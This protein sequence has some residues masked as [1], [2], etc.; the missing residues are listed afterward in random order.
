VTALLSLVLEFDEAYAAE[1][2]KR[3]L[4]DFSDLEHLAARILTDT[5]SGAPTETALAVSRRYREIMVDEYQDVSRVQERIFNAVSRD[6][7][8]IFMVGDVKQ[9][10]YRF[11]LA[12]PAI[13]LEKYKAYRDAAEAGPDEPRRVLLSTNFR[14]KAGILSAVNFVFKNVMSEDFGEMAYTEREFLYPGRTDEEPPGPAVELD[15]LDMS[16]AD[17]EKDGEEDGEEPEKTEVEAAFV[18]ARIEELLRSGMAVPDGQGGTRTIGCGDFAILLRSV[19]DKAPVYERALAERNIPASLPGG[20]GFFT[21]LEVSVALSLLGVIDNPR[22]DIPLIAVL[23]SPIY[24]FTPDELAVIRASDRNA[25][26]YGALVRAAETDAKCRSFLYELSSF[27][28]V[29][30]DMPADRFLWHVYNRTD[31][32]AVMGALKGGRER[33][34]NLMALVGLA[35][36]YEAGGYRGLFGFMTLV[37]KLIENGEEPFGAA[38]TAGSETAAAGAVRIMSIHKS[39][40]LEFPIVIIADTAKRFNK[41]DASAPLLI[42]AGLGVGAKRTDLERRI[43]YPTLARLAVARR[44][45]QE[46]MSEELRVLYVAMTRAKERLVV[47]STFADAGKELSKLEKEAAARSEAELRFA[48]Q[49]LENARSMAELILLPA[50]TRPEAGCLRQ[51]PV[52]LSPDDGYPW[53]IRRAAIT[54]TPA[55]SRKKVQ[56]EPP[57]VRAREEDIMALRENLGYSYPYL[58][59]AS[60]PS[61]LTATGLKGRFADYEAAEEAA[62][63]EYAMAGASTPGAN[64]ENTRSRYAPANRPAFITQRTSL[65]AAER[66]TALHLTMQY[67]DY[68]RCLTPDGV[69][70]EVAR[71]KA[72]NFLSEKQAD[73]VDAEKIT[74]FFKGPL[75]RRVMEAEKLYREFKFSLLVPAEDYS[76]GSA[77]GDEI[78]L[79]GVVDCCFEE[80][81]ALHVIDFKTDNVTEETLEEK[82]RLYAPQLNA[83]GHAM[84]RITGLPAASRIIWFF[85][86]DKAVQ[87]E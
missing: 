19:K 2:R 42:H 63:P 70:S 37:R 74:A 40:G 75:G 41:R 43:E 59:A 28:L 3:S 68:G 9:S 66:G 80:G 56:P 51:G 1:K 60:I 10:I 67:I 64:M 23:R 36:R 86:L 21:A 35:A 76:Y 48:P 8:N 24:N 39:K 46:T 79:Q 47:V 32:L 82:K 14:S 30:P 53:D 5:E 65:T 4:A 26:F 44:L 73:A 17:G 77:P 33:R 69:R 84:E 85:A 27:R 81:G 18:A 6:G 55:L 57:R 16:G 78:L 31:M 34:S 11:R 7:Q 71:L 13:F 50:L 83:Y 54:G 61:K 58:D 45:N 49:V 12:D 38:A 87:I 52:T 22:Q 29:A 62:T 25:D 72:A 15:V 20:E